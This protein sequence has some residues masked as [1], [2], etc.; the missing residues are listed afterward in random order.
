MD[1]R[2]E[3]FLAEVKGTLMENRLIRER[4][5]TLRE[6]SK[7]ARWKA[8]AMHEASVRTCRQGWAG[9]S[10]LASGGSDGDDAAAL[11]AESLLEHTRDAIISGKLPPTASYRSWGGPSTRGED[12]AI[13][14]RSIKRT[15]LAYEVEF[16]NDGASAPILQLHVRCFLTWQRER[17][18]W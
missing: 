2:L 16:A 3:V 12:C 7:R 6:E 5:T 9:L 17:R 4:S 10:W 18:K 11:S 1:T 14:Q 13:C 8:L 15:E